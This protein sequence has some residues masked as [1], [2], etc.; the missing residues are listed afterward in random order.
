MRR[1]FSRP[2]FS[3]IIPTLPDVETLT[4][5]GMA[6]DLL[7]ATQQFGLDKL[8]INFEKKLSG[9][10]DVSNVCTALALADQH[11]LSNL[12]SACLE[13]LTSPKALVSAMATDGI[14]HVVRSCPD[15]VKEISSIIDV[16]KLK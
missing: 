14:V 12:K 15:T 7:A 4:G 5:T 2:Y 8:R 9:G 6:Q 13:Y 3:T 1:R 10:L 16:A 11:R